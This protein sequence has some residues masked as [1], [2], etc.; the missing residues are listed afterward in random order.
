MFS[1]N[2]GTFYATRITRAARVGNCG[3]F[4]QR[5]ECVLFF[6]FMKIAK[7]SKTAFPSLL[8]NNKE[9]G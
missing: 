5:I 6:F 7:E 8:R 1:A 3:L 4:L 9:M 2:H